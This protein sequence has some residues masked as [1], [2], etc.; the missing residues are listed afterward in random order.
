M[1]CREKHTLMTIF[2]IFR[3]FVLISTDLLEMKIKTMHVFFLVV[4]CLIFKNYCVQKV[5][6]SLAVL[7]VK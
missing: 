4:S 3:I 2:G 1:Q 6:F 7:F 5:P